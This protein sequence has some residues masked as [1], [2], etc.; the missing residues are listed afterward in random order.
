MSAHFWVHRWLSYH[1]NLTWWRGWG[2]CGSLFLRALIL[3][4]RAPPSWPNHFPKAPLPNTITL[5]VRFQH[6]KPN[7]LGRG[8]TNFVH[9]CVQEVLL[10]VQG[11]LGVNHRSTPQFEQEAGVIWWEKTKTWKQWSGFW[12]WVEGVAS[13]RAGSRVWVKPW[14]SISL[15]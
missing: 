12:P 13:P 3:F 9:Y 5:G 15:V 2:S 7:T 1:C 11:S 14:T 8:D 10:L 4:T 6:V